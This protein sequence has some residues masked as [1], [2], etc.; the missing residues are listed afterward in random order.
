VTQNSH[1]APHR[2]LVVMYYNMRV[3]EKAAR[4]EAGAPRRNSQLPGAGQ[5]RAAAAGG[6]DERAAAVGCCR[7]SADV[8]YRCWLCRLALTLT[9]TC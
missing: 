8:C 3:S 4:A 5:P 9:Q 6:R 2:V 7:E 1:F